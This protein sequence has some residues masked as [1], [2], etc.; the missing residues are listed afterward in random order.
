MCQHTLRRLN[1]CQGGENP[2]AKCQQ[3]QSQEDSFGA[4]SAQCHGGFVPL[5]NNSVATT[6]LRFSA[7]HDSFK[8]QAMRST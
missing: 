1:S 5:C 2:A 7:P 4:A 6:A 3:T 8:A